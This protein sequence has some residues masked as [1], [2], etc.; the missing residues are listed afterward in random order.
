[1]TTIEAPSRPDLVDRA[2]GLVDV[3]RKHAAWQ[4]EH[5]VLHDDVIAGLTD[6]GVVQTRLPVRYGGSAPDA[7]TVC[8]AIAELGRGDGSVGWTVGTWTIGSWLAGLFPDEV[9]DEIFADPDTR[10]CGSVG[11]N[12]IAVPTKGGYTVNGTWH[13]ITGSK[14]SRWAVHSALVAGEDGG[15]APATVAV[16]IADLTIVDDWYTSGLRATGSVTTVAENLFVP[17]DRVLPMIPVLQSNRH[18]SKQN[19]DHQAWQVPFLPFAVAVSAAP[20]LG[21]ARAAWEVFFERL[22]NRKIVYTNYEKQIEAPL[23]H[24]QVAEAALKIDESEFHVLR[25]AHRLDDK[26]RTGQAWS[27]TERALARMDAGAACRLAREAVDV[28]NTA[29]GGSSI[30]SDVPMQRIARDVS[31]INLNGVMHPNTNAETYG[32]VLC[33]LEPNTNFL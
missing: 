26:S 6:T 31:A 18:L 12:G 5:R 19:A 4:E 11:P 24:L 10:V 21:M 32:R 16:P 14:Q 9:Q 8:E 33:G 1:M 30:Y 13:F 22:P 27:M 17:A 2:T 3:I 15:Y 23:T 20:A 7:R 29:S 28:L 25:S